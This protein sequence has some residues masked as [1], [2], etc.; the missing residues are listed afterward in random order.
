ME[1]LSK[2]WHKNIVEFVGCCVELPHLAIAM[3]YAHKGPL[4]ELL[5]NEDFLFGWDLRIKW[6][7]E[8]AEAVNYLHS[9]RPIVIHRDLKGWWK[10]DF[11]VLFFFFCSDFF[12]FFYRSQPTIFLFTETTLL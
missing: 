7:R 12:P 10:K 5:I 8:T 11:L 9:L 4:S 1:V 2:L 3:Q 6:A